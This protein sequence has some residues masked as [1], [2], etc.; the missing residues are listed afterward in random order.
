MLSMQA[1][2]RVLVRKG[3]VSEKEILEELASV[4][5]EWAESRAS[6]KPGR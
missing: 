2:V 6:A 3:I 1:M 4:K 5:R